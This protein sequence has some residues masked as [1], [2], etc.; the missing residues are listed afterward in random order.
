[1]NKLLQTALMAVLLVAP[2]F[3]SDNSD[4][5]ETCT[6]TGKATFENGMS[7]GSG[8]TLS[9]ADGAEATLA[10]GTTIEVMGTLEGPTTGTAAI[11][12]EDGKAT[13]D[14][15]T[16]QLETMES[17]DVTTLVNK[18]LGYSSEDMTY[19]HM[20]PLDEAGKIENRDNIRLTNVDVTE[21]SLL[22]EVQSINDSNK[23]LVLADN[24]GSEP[25]QMTLKNPNSDAVEIKVNLD[26]FYSCFLNFYFYSNILLLLLL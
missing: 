15:N 18:G 2:G 24:S 9:L 22:G 25:A 12:C 20:K 6:I 5:E 13:I 26:F 8:T 7:V 14:I 11:K 3:A 1:M 19:Y 16:S 17:S 4:D 10:K 23:T 21:N